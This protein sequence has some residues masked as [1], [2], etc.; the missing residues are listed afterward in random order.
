MEPGYI[1]Y[2]R[3]GRV[4]LQ[5]LMSQCVKNNNNVTVYYLRAHHDLSARTKLSAMRIMSAQAAYNHAI[6]ARPLYQ[7]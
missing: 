6:I 5:G 1:D 4:A 2:G 7:V 3:C